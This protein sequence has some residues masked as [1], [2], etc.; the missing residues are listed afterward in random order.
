MNDHNQKLATRG[1]SS[2]QARSGSTVNDDVERLPSLAR[3]N[4]ETLTAGPM[5]NSNDNVDN[6][7]VAPAP[8]RLIRWED[9]TN[10][11]EV[12]AFYAHEGRAPTTE[13]LGM[14]QQEFASQRRELESQRQHVQIMGP[15]IMQQI[16]H[17]H[18]QQNATQNALIA[19]TNA[20][21]DQQNANMQ[22][23]IRRFRLPPP[24]NAV[25]QQLPF[26][27][28]EPRSRRQQQN[29]FT[30][31]RYRNEMRRQG[32]SPGCQ[33]QE[34]LPSPHRQ[35]H[36]DEERFSRSDQMASFVQDNG[37]CEGK[38][39]SVPTEED[40][41]PKAVVANG[42]SATLQAGG[43]LMAAS[44]VDDMDSTGSIVDEGSN[45]KGNDAFIVQRNDKPKDEMTSSMARQDDDSTRP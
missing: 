14:W 6:H 8:P 19:F 40:G 34:L 37:V 3:P 42:V 18:D 31:N 21:R 13:E 2:G 23:L 16:Q 38:E 15:Q 32:F 27:T 28:P 29:A 22:D 7:Q 4:P 10:M 20:T 33:V 41:K 25:S 9:I 45:E 5:D 30:Q 24:E 1:Q 35:L 44:K 36:L 11:G 12:Y 26:S 43:E 39:N 17:M